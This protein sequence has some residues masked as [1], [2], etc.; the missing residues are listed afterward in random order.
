LSDI[1]TAWVF[2]GQ[3][4]QIVGMGKN[5]AENYPEIA[6]LYQ[7]ADEILG[8]A[9]SDLCFNGPEPLLTRT[10]NA[11]PAI[12]TTSL[13]HL[14]I[15]QQKHLEILG[16]PAFTAGHSLGEYTAL[17]ASGAL[18]FKD[19]LKLV[20]E[21]GRMMNEAGQGTS[22]M[23][24]VIGGDEILDEICKE[25]GTEVANYNS[26]G[27]TAISGTNEALTK[28]TELAKARGIKK[29]IPLSVSAAFHSTL[30]RPMA[31]ELGKLIAATPFNEATPPVISNV[32][33]KPLSLPE[34]IKRELVLQTYSPVRWVESVQ[35][36]LNGGVIRIIEIGTGKVLSGLIK[37]ISKD[38]ELV[39]SEDLLK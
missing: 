15:L 24:A 22:G 11:Q 10:D 9:L 28:F 17:V 16:T 30:M 5:L 39:N 19:A 20:R 38:V 8:F 14:K 7:E 12:L 35:T 37:R 34:E 36:M 29:V 2:P 18:G 21:R 1:A 4:S 32:T 6:A 33:A 25:S 26:P 27:Q 3:G 23:V 31:V 13:A